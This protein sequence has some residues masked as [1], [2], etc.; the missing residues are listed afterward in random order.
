MFTGVS[1]FLIVFI[2]VTIFLIVIIL[3]ACTPVL[4]VRVYQTCLSALR[5]LRIAILEIYN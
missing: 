1:I 5:H 4:S 2:G 3:S